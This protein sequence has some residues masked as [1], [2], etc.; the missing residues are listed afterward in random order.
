MDGNVRI[1]CPSGNRSEVTVIIWSH[2]YP[3]A[4]VILNKF[5]WVKQ[6]TIIAFH[7][8]FLKK[9]SLHVFSLQAKT[10]LGL[11]GEVNK[12]RFRMRQDGIKPSPL[13]EPVTK[14]VMPAGRYNSCLP[15]QH[16]PSH[17]FPTII[18]V[19]P[20]HYVSRMS[21]EFTA[22]VLFAACFMSVIGMSEILS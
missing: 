2:I 10:P 1:G 4:W 5:S 22:T 6:M 9:N 13:G 7:I 12:L 16:R 18:T 17:L 8:S 3:G 11:L 14:L 15:S 20:I 21:W 19:Q